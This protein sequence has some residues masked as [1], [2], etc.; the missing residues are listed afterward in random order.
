MKSQAL[1]VLKKVFGYDDFRPMQQDIVLSV[2]AGKDTLALLPTGGGK[3]ICFQVPALM[4]EG[5]CVVVSP[6]IALMKDQVDNLRRRGV[7][8]TAI[9]SGMR[10]REIDTTLDNCIYG[11]YKFLY[12]SPERLK[13]D[14]FIERFKRMNVNLIAIDEAH[15]ISQWGYDFRPPYLEIAELRNYHPNVPFIALTASATLRV[16]EDIIEKLQL[17]NPKIFIKSFARKNLS[18]AVRKAENKLEKAMEILQK[19]N[20]SA[21]VYVRSRK[22]TKELAIALHQLGISATYYHA[23]LDKSVREARQQD[24]KLNKIRVMVATN[25]FGMGIDKPDVRLVVH[26]DIPENLENY[27]QEAG[28]AGRD[29]WKAFAVILFHDR[30]M[31]LLQERA[32]Q[33]YPPVEFIKRVYQSLANYYRIAVGSSLM[34]SYDF[35]ITTFT[36]IYNLD[37]LLTYNAIK[38]LQEE[39][40]VE[41]SEGF[42]SPSTLHF[43][44]NQSELYA[45][46]IAQASLDPLIKVLLRMYGGELFTEYLKIRE[47]KIGAMLNMS[48][49]QVVSLMERMETLGI[50]AYNK[51]KDKPQVTFLTPRHDAGRLPLNV[52]RIDERRRNS[53]EK[54]K[55]MVAYVENNLLCRTQQI[56]TYFGEENDEECGVCD[57]CLDKK[58]S[59]HLASHSFKL[60]ERLMQTLNAGN[61]FTYKELLAKAN[62]ASDDEKAHLM[63]R[64][65]EDEGLIISLADGRIKRNTE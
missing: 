2:A 56:L 15:C 60:K 40:L 12:V 27:Y 59:S 36:E 63:L 53:V 64:E 65:M 1:S 13:T 37:L 46:Q 38:L 20:G 21:I 50:A 7:L 11:G 35:E 14:L 49:S 44:V 24:W 58:R 31:D 28:R 51:K 39:G 17:D 10:K 29:E 62:L 57:V 41:L 34:V 22:A 54:A 55:A 33:A 52:K 6:L 42:Y 9:Y 61:L 8:A 3:S 30:D 43:L 16:K 18:Y 19:V 48:E 45:Y 47:D 26:V 25:A 32:E 23:G 5:I 4:Q